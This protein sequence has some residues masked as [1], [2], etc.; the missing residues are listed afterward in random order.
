MTG[1]IWI[2]GRHPVVEALRSGVARTVLVA[3]GGNHG[4][5][6]DEIRRAAREQG[7]DLREVPRH[8]MERLAPGERTQ[9]VAAEVVR[10]PFLRVGDLLQSASQPSFFVAMDHLQDPHNVGA[11]LRTAEAAGV[12]GIILPQRRSAPLAG[13]VAKVSAG[14][15]SYLPIAEVPN[16]A[17]AL[18]DLRAGGIWTVGLDG[19]ADLSL[20]DADLTVPLALVLGAEGEGLRRLTR[21]HCD[22]LVRLPMR[23]RVGSLNVSVAGGIAMYEVLRQREAGA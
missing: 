13:V 6:V 12:G 7:V 18:D 3:S 17:R 4:H 10:A 14:A 22:F 2:W 11:V 1:T 9:G 8:E 20:Y 16:L 21:E 5:I 23:G 15:M 19:A